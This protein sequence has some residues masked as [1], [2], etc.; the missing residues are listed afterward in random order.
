VDKVCKKL[1]NLEV[2]KKSLR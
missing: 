1:Q 2:E